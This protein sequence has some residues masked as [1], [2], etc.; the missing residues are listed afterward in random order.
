MFENIP[1][2]TKDILEEI[3]DLVDDTIGLASYKETVYVIPDLPIIKIKPLTP[4]I[5]EE[6]LFEIRMVK[7]SDGDDIKKLK[8]K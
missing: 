2:K 1:E 6:F 3:I 7:K 5:K 4:R 8:K